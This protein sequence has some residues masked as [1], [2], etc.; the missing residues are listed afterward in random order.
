MDRW[1]ARR[2]SL[3]LVLLG[4]CA[5]SSQHQA[6]DQHGIRMSHLLM[7]GCEKHSECAVR[8]RKREERPDNSTCTA[9]PA[10]ASS[11]PHAL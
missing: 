2:L 10:A 1:G 5:H 7:N 3:R 11:L 8:V 9:R 4:K 6:Q